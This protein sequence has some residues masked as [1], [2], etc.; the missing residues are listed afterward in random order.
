MTKPNDNAARRVDI[1]TVEAAQAALRTVFNIARA[2]KLTET[3]TQMLLGAEDATFAQWREGICPAPLDE[4]S[5]TRVSHLLN[6]YAALQILLPIPEQ[7]D[8]WVQR[9]NTAPLFC[10]QP[11]LERMLS[12]GVEDLE[13]VAQYL[14][15]QCQGNFA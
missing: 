4:A 1:R 8:A 6:I 10:G 12:G 13:A 14:N 11:A 3:Q 2:W 15:V 7:A 5:L 9:P